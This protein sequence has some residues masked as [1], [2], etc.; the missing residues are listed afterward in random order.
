M[1][2]FF[3]EPTEIITVEDF[4]GTEVHINSSWPDAMPNYRIA[5]RLLTPSDSIVEDLPS[6]NIW[7]VAGGATAVLPEVA[8]GYQCVVYVLS[9]YHA[10]LW[11]GGSQM[12]G[13]DVTTDSAVATLIRLQNKWLI[14][15]WK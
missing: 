4:G 10:E 12:I 9:G 2:E 11:P 14:H 3:E 13:P 6:T 7:E 15:V 1:S 8:P 5:S